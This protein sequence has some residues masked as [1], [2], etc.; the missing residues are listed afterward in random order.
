MSGFFSVLALLATAQGFAVENV[1]IEIGDGTRMPT[2]TVVVQNGV[3]TKVGPNVEIPANLERID[4]RGKVLAPGFVEVW[5]QLGLFEVPA[6]H[7]SVDT[8]YEGRSATPGF[9]AY[10]GFN[11]ESVRIPIERRGGV[12][13]V[14]ASPEGQ[15]L[16]GTGF[17]FDLTG[18]PFA[19]DARVA[20]AAM[21]GNVG[22]GGARAQGNARG[23]A[24]LRL[25]EIFDDVRAYRQNRRGFDKGASRP[26]SLPPL[27]LQAVAPVLRGEIP[28]ALEVHRASDIRALLRF[29]RELWRRGER[30]RLVI[31]GGS[32][33]WMVRDAIAA[34][35][36]PVVV[37]TSAQ[38]P[39]A[40]ETLHAR[41]DGVTLLHRAGVE[42]L[43][44]TYGWDSNVRRLRQEAGLAVAEGMPYAAAIA[45]ISGTPARV[46]G[47]NTI[48]TVTQ[49]KRANLV[50][51]SA[52][53][54]ELSSVAEAIWIDG[55]RQPAGD[56][57]RAL[58][59]KYHVR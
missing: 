37:V 43:I 26:L 3:I 57:Q 24:W 49:G 30:V 51:W 13:T 34:E 17:F 48:G 46:F 50:L 4:G 39:H 53:P 20:P 8:T 22:E 16:Y 35:H 59:E 31:L 5:T 41:D 15:L 28:L 33:A 55:V 56:R 47:Q 10:D 18:K 6:V 19:S 44:S 38:V 7:A 52:D 54:L 45:S 1:K 40:F 32:E 23:G 29:K 25:R 36:V 11:P 14:L 58:A 21:F 27:H 12:T 2:G 42:V 9:F